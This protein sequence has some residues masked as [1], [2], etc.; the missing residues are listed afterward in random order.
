[1]VKSAGRSLSAPVRGSKV[2]VWGWSTGSASRTRESRGTLTV[3]ISEVV[4]G[5]VLQRA[6]GAA[7]QSQ[8]SVLVVGSGRT[9]I[10]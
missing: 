8:V 1:M 7:V 4:V 9:K 10:T 3:R 2:S 6:P 5:C